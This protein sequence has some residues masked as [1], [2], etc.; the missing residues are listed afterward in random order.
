VLLI[1]KDHRVFSG[2]DIALKVS[3]LN[4]GPMGQDLPAVIRRQ[5]F[6][7]SFSSAK[8]A[9]TWRGDFI[10]EII[11]FHCFGVSVS[12]SFVFVNCLPSFG[13]DLPG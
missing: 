9:T 4:A 8:F 6:G 1:L 11:A 7:I 13:L 12:E 5:T 10:G 3:E 2:A